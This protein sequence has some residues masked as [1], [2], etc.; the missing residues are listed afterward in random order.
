MVRGEH[1]TYKYHA[2][3]SPFT[4]QAFEDGPDRG[5][6]NVSQSNQTL[7]I[8]PKIDTVDTFNLFMIE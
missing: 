4:L 1:G 2:L 6:R 5:V 7:G 8:H 3:P